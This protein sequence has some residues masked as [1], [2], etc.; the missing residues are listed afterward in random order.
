[1]I[2]K[3][4]LRPFAFR[5]IEHPHL[6]PLLTW[7]PAALAAIIVILFII[8]P[9]MP[10]TLGPLGLTGHVLSFVSILP[11]FYIAALAAVATFDRDRLDLEMEDPAPALELETRGKTSSVPL[12]TRMFLCHM[13]SYL[14]ALSF[15]TVVICIFGNIV[16]PSVS[17]ILV[18]ILKTKFIPIAVL[19]LKATFIFLVTWI[20]AQILLV[21]MLGLYFLAERIHRPNA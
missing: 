9:V 18:L 7:V 21:T 19:G 12:S 3:L 2:I 4:L 20:V 1:M 10:P 11:G 8:L 17:A 6:R 14:T 16:G 13:F 5:K 15:T